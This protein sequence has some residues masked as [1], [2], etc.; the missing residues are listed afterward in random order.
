MR[1]IKLNCQESVKLIIVGN[2]NDI[3]GKRQITANT[4]NVFANKLDIAYIETSAKTE[5]NVKDAFEA[6]VK[7]IYYD[8]KS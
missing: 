2:K 1:D 8:K 7:K 3:E 4:A 6:I 5:C